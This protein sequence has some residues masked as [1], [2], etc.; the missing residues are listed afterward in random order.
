LTYISTE[1]EIDTRELISRC[2]ALEKTVAVPRITAGE[3]VFYEIKSL[4]ETGKSKFGILEPVKSTKKAQINNSTF[5]VVPALACNGNGFRL[6][7]GGGFYDR[8]LSSFS[9][10]SA[11]LCYSYNII[12]IPVEAYD[13]AVDIVITERR[14]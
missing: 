7:Y 6:G 13:R 12:E 4:N 11:A 1:S 10:F 5:C 14:D 8:F 2:F 9:G 3:I